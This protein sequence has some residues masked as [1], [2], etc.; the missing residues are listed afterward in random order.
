V[1]LSGT[2]HL[3]LNSA[4]NPSA[5]I[6]VTSRFAQTSIQPNH[7]PS[8]PLTKNAPLNSQLRPWPQARL[9]ANAVDQA[10]CYG[11]MEHC[12]DVGVEVTVGMRN[13]HISRLVVIHDQ[14]ILLSI[15]N[16]A[17]Y[18]ATAYLFT[19]INSFLSSMSST[20]SL[21]MD[22]SPSLRPVPTI[23]EPI[24]LAVSV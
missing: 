5:N 22:H 4:L 1:A 11:Q 8:R 17:M 18:V 20:Q 14:W 12:V 23:F 21:S 16:L 24:V 6:T 2:E 3:S 7:V 9:D 13:R 10:Y 15:S 19:L